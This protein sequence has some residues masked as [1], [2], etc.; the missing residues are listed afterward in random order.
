M[1]LKQLEYFLRIA[2]LGSFTKAAALLRVAQPA[3]SRQVKQLEAE[4]KQPLLIRNGR[5]AAPTDAG[6]TL[7][8]HAR[9]ILHQ[10]AL[11]KEQVSKGPTASA[12]RVSIGLPTSVA[13]V[14]TVALTHASRSQLP[15]AVLSV[16]EGLSSALQEALIAG[17]IDIALLYNPQAASDLQIAP[18][19][20]EELFLVSKAPPKKNSHSA[21]RNASKPL[22]LNELKSIPL[23]IPTRPNAIR[24]LVESELSVFGASP[25]ILMEIDGVS[26]IMD[27]VADGLGHAVLPMNAIST[28]P[29]PKVF[30]TQRIKGL[31]SHLVMASSTQRPATATQL[32]MQKILAELAKNL[33]LKP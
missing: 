31:K 12:A 27:L 7:A 26:A 6:R 18:L 13:K 33:L 8:E 10:V 24:M 28:A 20:F 15:H 2:E 9:G 16:T 25:T 30:H 11:A 17:R 19:L 4:L 3:L 22:S 21:P 5:G 29:I 1:D 14:L 32:Q 23:I